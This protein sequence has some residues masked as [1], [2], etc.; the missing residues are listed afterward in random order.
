VLYHQRNP[1]D[2]LQQL[3]QT[4]RPGG[5]LVLETIYLPG[6]AMEAKTPENR[7]ARMRNVWLLPTI[8]QLTKWV[9]DCGFVDIVVM[10][11][12]MTTVYEQRATDWMT[13][14]SLLEALDPN[15]PTLTVEGWPAPHRAVI[16]ATAR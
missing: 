9:S 2:H 5:Q 11:E 14:E 1:L 7:Y 15:D 6:E 16:T 8:P 3:L 12:S 10:D 4:L 13:S